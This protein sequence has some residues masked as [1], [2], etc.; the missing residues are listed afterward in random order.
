MVGTAGRVATSWWGRSSIGAHTGPAVLGTEVSQLSP[1]SFGVWK[2]MGCDVFCWV[3]PLGVMVW[4]TSLE[5]GTLRIFFGML[6]SLW[7]WDFA[8]QIW[9]ISPQQQE[10]FVMLPATF[11]EFCWTWRCCIYC[12][13][14]SKVP[15]AAGSA[16]RSTFFKLKLVQWWIIVATSKAH[17]KKSFGSPR[18]VDKYQT[19][20]WKPRKMREMMV[21]HHCSDTNVVTPSAQKIPLHSSIEVNPGA[22]LHDVPLMSLQAAMLGRAI[23]GGKFNRNNKLGYW[24]VMGRWINSC[25]L[26]DFN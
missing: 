13:K 22:A 19:F 15:W 24:K 20:A 11:W 14:V 16:T 8:S 12:M 1:K 2:P 3:K 17:V 26:M 6:L 18:Q 10:G 25:F 9:I 21:F 23:S 5:E 7:V 4:S